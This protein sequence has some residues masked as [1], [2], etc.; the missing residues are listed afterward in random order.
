MHIHSGSAAEEYL[1]SL[2]EAL[3]RDAH[4]FEHWFLL[5]GY[6]TEMPEEIWLQQRSGIIEDIRTKWAGVSVDVVFLERPEVLLISRALDPKSLANLGQLMGVETSHSYTLSA[7]ADEVLALLG[8]I[9]PV[10]AIETTTTREEA[11]PIN[12]ALAEAFRAAAKR[13]SGR[14]HLHVLLVEDDPTMVRMVGNV[15]LPRYELSVAYDADQALARYTGEAPDIVFLDIGL[16]QVNGFELLRQIRAI[17]PYAY[18]VMFS[19]HR[20]LDF[21]CHALTLGASGFVGKPFRRESME[22]YLG[23]CARRTRTDALNHWGVA[24]ATKH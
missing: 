19:G 22:Y 5:H 4:S 7:Q 12:A 6:F 20:N 18:V 11:L 13:R 16:P 14:A 23:D 9:R 21:I 8:E 24:T 1:A 15:L 17:D 10:L 3:V 2:R